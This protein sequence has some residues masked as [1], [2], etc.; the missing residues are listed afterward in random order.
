LLVEAACMDREFAPK[1][2]ESIRSVLAERFDLS[3]GETETLLELAT[4][5]NASSIEIF[6]F[7]RGLAK[8]MEYDE[9]VHVIE[10]L[11]EVAHADDV[12]TA[13]EDALIRRVAGLLYVTD[14]D[15]GEARRRALARKPKVSPS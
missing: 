4:K 13:E 7:T 6:G 8:R 11:W 3:G 15:R 14:R 1:E 2:R 12:L 10:M 5:A 9:R